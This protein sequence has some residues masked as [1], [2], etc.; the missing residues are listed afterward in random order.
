MAV[1]EI[2]IGTAGWSYPTGPGSWNGVFYP[3]GRVDELEFYAHYFD[4]V[5]INSTF[6]RPHTPAMASAWVRRTPRDFKFA[7]KLFQKFTH[8]KMFEAQSGQSEDPTATDADQF[9]RSLDPLVRAGK[10]SALLIQLPPSCHNGES[11]REKLTWTL[12]Q[13]RDYPLA[14]EFRHESWSQSAAATDRFLAEYKASWVQIDEP[15]F[16]SSIQ[17]DFRP[18][19]PHYYLRFHGRNKDQWWAKDAS[20]KRYD[21]LYAREEL[22]PFAEKVKEAQVQSVSVIFNNHYGGKAVANAMQFRALLGQKT[23]KPPDSLVS[24]FSFLK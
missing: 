22:E 3:R 13:F 24:K 23:E 5:E 14:V 1:K 12:R 6:Y 15:K 19:G 20:E 9:R 8:P 2:R 16:D 10:L 7:V 21:Y 18:H 4:I 17:Q 11:S